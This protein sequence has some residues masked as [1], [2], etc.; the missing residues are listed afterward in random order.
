MRDNE[1]SCDPGDI[2]CVFGTGQYHIS[3]KSTQGLYSLSGKTAYRQILWSFEATRLDIAMVVS[4]WNLTGISAAVLSERS[5]KFKPESRGFETSRD[6]AVRR[7]T[8]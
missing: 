7:L 6:L 8:A 4:L 3:W 2:A 5:E 1:D